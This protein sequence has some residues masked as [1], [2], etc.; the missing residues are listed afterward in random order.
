MVVNFEIHQVYPMFTKDFKLDFQPFA[1]GVF[2]FS[3]EQQGGGAPDCEQLNDLII[4]KTKQFPCSV[5]SKS[6]IWTL[7]SSN[8]YV[9]IYKKIYR[10]ERER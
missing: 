1:V 9:Y 6:S 7:G 8:V 3:L 10:E 2:K 5:S 4:W